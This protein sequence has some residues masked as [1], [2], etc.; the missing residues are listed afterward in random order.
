VLIYPL[1]FNKHLWQPALSP[2]VRL[3]YSYLLPLIGDPLCYSQWQR[4]SR[5]RIFFIIYPRICGQRDRRFRL[6]NIAN[7]LLNKELVVVFPTFLSF[8]S[9]P[10]LTWSCHVI[11]HVIGC[12]LYS[13]CELSACWYPFFFFFPVL[14]F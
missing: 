1:K 4:V 7:L 3:L 6:A 2:P 13:S 5:W 9:R 8:M 12:R 10:R 11:G 14:V